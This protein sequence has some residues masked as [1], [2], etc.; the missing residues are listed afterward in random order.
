MYFIHYNLKSILSEFLTLNVEDD[1]V[2]FKHASSLLK[3]LSFLFIFPF[4]L[5]IFWRF[6]IGVCDACVITYIFYFIA[7]IF[8]LTCSYLYHTKKLIPNNP[9]LLSSSFSFSFYGCV[10]L[11]KVFVSQFLIF[12]ITQFESNW[13]PLPSLLPSSSVSVLSSF[14]SFSDETF[15]Y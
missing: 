3:S 6:H 15:L 7:F 1:A 9:L 4:I 2:L 10:T 12:F 14:R 5:Q 11:E 8:S 13:I